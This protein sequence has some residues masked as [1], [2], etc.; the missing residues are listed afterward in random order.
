[1]FFFIAGLFLNIADDAYANPFCNE[2]SSYI[3]PVTRDFTSCDEKIIQK[4]TGNLYIPL[5]AHLRGL[6]IDQDCISLANSL[7]N[8]ISKLPPF[9]GN[10]F[11]GTKFRDVFRSLNLG[12]CYTDMGFLSTSKNLITASYLFAPNSDYVIFDIDVSSGRDI[13]NHSQTREEEVLLLPETIL[14]LKAI[15][16]YNSKKLFKFTEVRSHECRIIKH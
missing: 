5:N 14:K 10:V 12:D 15:K 1:M 11:R 7:N 4:Y 16:T 9:K 8:A 2:Y 3:C 13:T 6:E